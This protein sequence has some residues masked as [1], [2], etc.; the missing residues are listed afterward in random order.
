MKNKAE[1]SNKVSLVLLFWEFCKVGL[2]TI[3]GGLVM[4]P[5]I[6]RVAVDEKKWIT[7]DEMLDCIALSQAVPGMIALNVATFVGYKKRGAIGGIVASVGVVLPSFIIILLLAKTLTSIGDNKYLQG[8]FKGVK[9]AVA[10]LIVSTV[11]F[12]GK[13]N[14]KTIFQWTMAIGIFVVVAVLKAN[15]IVTILLAGAVGILYGL[16]AEKK[17]IG[18]IGER[19]ISFFK[20]DADIKNS[21]ESNLKNGV[22]NKDNGGENK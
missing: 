2:F 9:S 17:I 15:A 12:L 10:G 5:V 16:F 21:V 20:K 1:K 14:L 7:D 6:S 8:A 11:Y 4:I 3:G 22:K 13:K 19:K 18:D